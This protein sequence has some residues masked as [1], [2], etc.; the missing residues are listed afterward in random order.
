LQENG[1]LIAKVRTNSGELQPVK[2]E[3]DKFTSAD[4]S[5]VAFSRDANGKVVKIKMDA[6]GMTFEGVKQ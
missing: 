1:K 6:L 4:G 3:K 2:D 5:T